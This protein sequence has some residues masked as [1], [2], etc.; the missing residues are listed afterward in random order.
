MK[1]FGLIPVNLADMVSVRHTYKPR[2]YDKNQTSLSYY[3]N[4]IYT[5]IS[6]SLSITIQA[7]VPP[8]MPMAAL[9]RVGVAA[10]ICWGDK[11]SARGAFV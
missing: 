4:L 10:L 1:V 5:Q 3:K 2:R 11:R 9:L 8:E 7:E 6:G